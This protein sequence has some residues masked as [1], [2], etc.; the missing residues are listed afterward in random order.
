MELL[1]KKNRQFIVYFAPEMEWLSNELKEKYPK[2]FI[3]STIDWK[4]HPDGTPNIFI[5]DIA[6]VKNRHVLFLASF[7][8]Y[9]SKYMQMSAIYVLTRSKVRTMVVSLPFINTAT[10]ERV[11]EEGQIATADF[12]AWMMSSLPRFGSPIE[13][14]VYDLHTLQNRHYFHDGAILTMAT[15][16]DIFKKKLVELDE[17]VTIAFPDEGAHKRFGGK[18][19]EYSQIICGKVRDGDKRIVKIASGSPFG[20][21]VFI[22]DDLVQSG[23]TLIQCKNVLY[24][25]G[26]RA[27]SAYVTHA[28]FPNQSWK[29]FIHK[30]DDKPNNDF[31]HF[32][33]SNTYPTVN[34]FKGKAP[35]EVLSFADDLTTHL[36]Y[37]TAEKWNITIKKT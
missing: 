35:F 27:V 36:I 12:D 29:K 5:R 25:Q 10:M 17:K 9:K 22:V 19:P 8:D 23:G 28:I 24:E 34:E 15:G 33:V 21:H 30:D 20:Q 1:L 31:K 26:A 11:T 18:F 4:T 32:I 14:V 6:Q 2:I 3:P 7:H 13:F 16:I 37:D